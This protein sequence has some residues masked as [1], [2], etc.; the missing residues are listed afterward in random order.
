MRFKYHK[1]SL[2]N[3]ATSLK[4][5]KN[6]DNVDWFEAFP[7]SLKNIMNYN[8]SREIAKNPLVVISLFGRFIVISLFKALRSSEIRITLKILQ[9]NQ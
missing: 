1:I 2:K 8:E 3:P 5:Q 7:K 6:A 9:K 4:M